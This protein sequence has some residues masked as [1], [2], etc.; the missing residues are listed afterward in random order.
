[1]S[2][3][4]SVSQ[5]GPESL[6][7]PRKKIFWGSSRLLCRMPAA[8]G[9]IFTAFVSRIYVWGPPVAAFVSL[10]RIPVSV[11]NRSQ[12]GGVS[13]HITVIF[14]CYHVLAFQLFRN[15]KHFFLICG[16]MGAGWGYF[17]K[18]KAG[19]QHRWNRWLSLPV[20]VFGFY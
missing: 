17:S 4:R 12:T 13:A 3:M 10:W 6:G 16:G 5:H 11:Q 8:H 19:G 7:K 1:M 20:R 14:N 9:S 15:R 18:G 2:R